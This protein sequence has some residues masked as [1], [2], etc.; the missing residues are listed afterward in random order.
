MTT[1]IYTIKDYVPGVDVKTR[2]TDIV[3]QWTGR[4]TVTAETKR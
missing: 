4:R 3:E 2:D 1:T